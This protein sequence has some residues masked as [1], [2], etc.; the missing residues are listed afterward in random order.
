MSNGLRIRN[1]WRLAKGVNNYFRLFDCRMT[2]WKNWFVGILEAYVSA[3]KDG[4]RTG[5]DNDRSLIRVLRPWH[6]VT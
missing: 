6:K 1:V 2:A 4:A 3:G 5:P